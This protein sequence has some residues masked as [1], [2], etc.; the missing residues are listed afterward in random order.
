MK[1]SALFLCVSVLLLTSCQQSATNERI[2]QYEGKSVINLDGKKILIEGVG[3]SG[4]T[5]FIVVRHAEKQSNENP[6][7]NIL[8]ADR[9]N[10]LASIL[11]D[12]PLKAIY[13]TY[14][15]RTRETAGP[16]AKM[17]DLEIINYSAEH[18]EKLFQGIAKRGKGE[19]YLI[20]GHSNTIPQL[21]NL[22]K[23]KAVYENIDENVFDNLFVV[24]VKNSG[25]AEILE[26]KY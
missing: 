6:G 12:F 9:A 16:C 10:R 8:G 13:S 22:F 20:V 14:T 3:E 25:Q 24:I 15:N 11:E 7:L 17:K 18:Q 19:A 1:R 26:L 2:D 21:L 5:I 23:G 4:T